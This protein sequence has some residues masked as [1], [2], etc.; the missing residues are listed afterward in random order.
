MLKNM[1]Q[2]SLCYTGRKFSKTLTQPGNKIMF[3]KFLFHL[4]MHYVKFYI[5][6]IYYFQNR[7]KHAVKKRLSLIEISLKDCFCLPLKSHSFLHWAESRDLVF[8]KSSTVPL[9]SKYGR[10][11]SFPSLQRTEAEKSVRGPQAL[12]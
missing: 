10:L 3:F 2:I 5:M 11:S 1:I 8:F 7:N 12:K 4:G 6:R 9:H